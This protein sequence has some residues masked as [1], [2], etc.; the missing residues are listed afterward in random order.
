MDE[1]IHAGVK[2]PSVEPEL[3]PIMVGLCAW[4]KNLN[5]CPSV[6]YL[7]HEAAKGALISGSTQSDSGSWL[8]R[9]FTVHELH[10]QSK[11]WF[12]R[13]PTSSDVA[14]KPS[15]LD[16]TELVAES[17]SRVDINWTDLLEQCQKHESDKWGDG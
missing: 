6:L 13:V 2:I 5:H 9:T 10:E 7:S 16:V 3:L 15:R 12:A 8:V 4:E 14:N 1:S 11:A 17:V